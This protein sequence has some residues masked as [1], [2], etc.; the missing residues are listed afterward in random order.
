MKGKHHLRLCLAAWAMVLGLTACNYEDGPVLSLRS[1]L[2]RVVGEK[3]VVYYEHNGIDSTEA[4]NQRFQDSLPGFR[5]SFYFSID[6]YFDVYILDWS[7]TSS[8]FGAWLAGGEFETILLLWK[9]SG[10]GDWDWTITRLTNRSLWLEGPDG[11]ILH[12]KK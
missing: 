8:E 7:D 10:F 5:G 11:R 1:K 12:F 9:G 4:L 3:R 2:H 6:T